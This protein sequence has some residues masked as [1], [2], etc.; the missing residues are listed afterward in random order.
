MTQLQNCR[1]LPSTPPPPS[2]KGVSIFASASARGAQHDAEPHQHH[3][4]S[5]SRG[6]LGSRFPLA[7]HVRQ[8]ATA[9]GT[10]LIEKFIP[11]VAIEA[12]CRRGDEHLRRRR[13]FRQPLAQHAGA[14]Y[15]AFADAVLP[16]RGPAACPNVLGSQ[17]YDPID[18][19]QARGVE[20]TAAGVPSDLPLRAPPRTKGVTRWPPMVN[21]GINAPPIRP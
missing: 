6:R 8:E 4:D 2:L 10:V 7:H 5:R 13:Q 21:R 17:V 16:Q 18:A 12:N 19:R 20:G 3:S 15:A 14:V 11:A 9:S 1:P